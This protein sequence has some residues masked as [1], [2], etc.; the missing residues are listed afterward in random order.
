[1]IALVHFSFFIDGLFTFLLSFQAT[2]QDLQKMILLVSDPG[3]W[4]HSHLNMD[5]LP[6]SQ[7]QGSYPKFIYLIS[8]EKK[9]LEK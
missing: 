9:Q 1:M 8:T 6:W 5:I 2:D 7:D 3:I 4:T